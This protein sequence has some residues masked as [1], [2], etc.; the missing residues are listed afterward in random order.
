MTLAT[1]FFN[2]S[3]ISQNPRYNNYL[4]SFRSKG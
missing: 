2:Q 3:K 4:F 1:L